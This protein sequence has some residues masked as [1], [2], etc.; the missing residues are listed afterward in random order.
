MGVSEGMGFPKSRIRKFGGELSPNEAPSL[1]WAL[2]TQGVSEGIG[3]P[4]SR[5]RV[6]AGPSAPVRLSDLARPVVTRCHPLSPRRVLEGM[7]FPK[8]KIRVLVG[9]SAPVRPL[10]VTHISVMVIG[11]CVTVK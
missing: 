7:G 1:D 6:S 4:K 10:V 8:S 5:I 2:H 9:N 3:F 11:I